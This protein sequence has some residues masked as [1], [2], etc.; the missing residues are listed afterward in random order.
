[1]SIASKKN[2]G[3]ES[4]VPVEI[5]GQRK[6]I[7]ARLGATGM[8]ADRFCSPDNKGTESKADARS[9][10]ALVATF[11]RAITVAVMNR[12]LIICTYVRDNAV[13]GARNYE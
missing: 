9:Q 11:T 5:M 3:R 7:T 12:C 13:G 2:V 10:R 8:S 4:R 1:M 6:A